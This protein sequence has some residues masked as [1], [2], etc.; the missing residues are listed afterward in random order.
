MSTYEVFNDDRGELRLAGQTHF[1]RD[2]GVSTTFVYDTAYLTKGGANIDPS[3]QL[4][5]G[6]QHQDGLLRA[7]ADSAPDRWGRNLIDK[8]EHIAARESNRIPRRLDDVTYLL[9]VNDNTRQG[10]LR[11]R[12]PGAAEFLDADA[13]VPKFVMLPKLLRLS[14]ELANEQDPDSAVK[15]LLDTGTTGL[16]LGMSRALYAQE[17]PKSQRLSPSPLT[18]TKGTP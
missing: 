11:F 16:D 7:F 13:Q 8:A 5:A 6:P 12:A 3:L 9:G 1:T 10:A 17:L 15:Q 4:V 18:P 14:D 2:R